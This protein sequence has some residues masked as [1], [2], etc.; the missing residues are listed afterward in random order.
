MTSDLSPNAR[1]LTVERNRSG[2]ADGTHAFVAQPAAPAD[3]VER[4]LR[5]A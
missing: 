5:D 4:N 1:T 3:E 2:I